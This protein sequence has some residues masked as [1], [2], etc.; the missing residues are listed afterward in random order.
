MLQ[1]C[2]IVFTTKFAAWTVPN[3][4]FASTRVHQCLV[5]LFFP[6][7]WV[8]KR[9]FDVKCGHLFAFVQVSRSSRLKVMMSWIKC[10]KFTFTRLTTRWSSARKLS[11]RKWWIRRLRQ[12]VCLHLFQHICKRRLNKNDRILIK[13]CFTY[14]SFSSDFICN[15]ISTR[16]WVPASWLLCTRSDH[17]VDVKT[18]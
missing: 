15:F 2:H 18:L 12:E 4:N 16:S 1:S 6:K 14:C 17:F 9:C 13:N 8:Q 7:N 10:V 3:F 5:S 11:R